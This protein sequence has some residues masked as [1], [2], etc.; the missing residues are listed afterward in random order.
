MIEGLLRIGFRQ[1]PD[2]SPQCRCANVAVG[3]YGTANELGR[4]FRGWCEKLG[5]VVLFAA[6]LLVVGPI[7]LLTPAVHEM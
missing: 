7:F 4:I 3:R 2:L 5:I 1:I 6:E